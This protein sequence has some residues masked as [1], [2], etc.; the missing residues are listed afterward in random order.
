MPMKRRKRG[1]PF[2]PIHKKIGLPPGKY[3]AEFAKRTYPKQFQEARRLRVGGLSLRG[4]DL[5]LAS[6]AL[7]KRPAEF[8][9]ALKSGLSVKQAFDVAV[10][11]RPWPELAEAPFAAYRMSNKTFPQR[12]TTG[13]KVPQRKRTW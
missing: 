4:K 13:K 5:L 12:A 1:P 2:E 11:G 7:E 9:V 10:R 8:R 3:E 6:S